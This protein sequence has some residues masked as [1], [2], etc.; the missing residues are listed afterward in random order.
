MLKEASDIKTIDSQ[1]LAEYICYRC[2]RMSHLKLQKL[3]YYVQAMHLAYFKRPVIDDDFEAWVHGP[4]SRKIFNS[5]RDHSLL[6]QE[7]QYV[8][9][10]DEILPDLFLKNNLLP[11]QIDIIDEVLD[12]YG[13]LSALK[14]ESLTHS[15]SPWI[16]ARKGYG[17]ADRCT[18]IIR[19]D[20]MMEYYR[21]QVYGDVED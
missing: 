6:H 16:A 21:D 19:K 8:H 14:L 13:K 5:L 2:G 10:S 1:K 7:L 15:E 4:V 3:L 12:E 9:N 17:P 20:V 18:N 11:D